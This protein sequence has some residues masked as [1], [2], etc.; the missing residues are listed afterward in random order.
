ME[1]NS[2]GACVR[3]S[4]LEYETGTSSYA[5]AFCCCHDICINI[6]DLFD[7]FWWNLLNICTNIEFSSPKYV[8][9]S[10][11]SLDDNTIEKNQYKIKQQI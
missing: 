11:S 4:I 2:N 1:V 6:I 10:N 3:V 8:T 9:P 7:N 5:K